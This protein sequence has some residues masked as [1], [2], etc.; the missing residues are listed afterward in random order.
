MSREAVKVSD[1]FIQPFNELITMGN[2]ETFSPCCPNPTT[3]DTPD[4]HKRWK[5]KR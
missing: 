2:E 1:S 3:V 4:A 5:Q